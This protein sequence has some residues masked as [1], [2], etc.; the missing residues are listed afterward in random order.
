M[1]SY[2]DGKSNYMEGVMLIAL[3]VVVAL[4]CAFHVTLL[5]ARANEY[6]TDSLGLL[7]FFH[8]VLSS[9]Y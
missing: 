7:T 5:Y 2:R 4:A 9:M 6:A 8:N 3:Y 1:L